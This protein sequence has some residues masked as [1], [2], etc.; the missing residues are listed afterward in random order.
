MRAVSDHQA[1]TTQQHTTAAKLLTTYQN[2]IL[3]SLKFRQRWQTLSLLALEC[4]LR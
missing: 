1:T 3:I 2:I 4:R